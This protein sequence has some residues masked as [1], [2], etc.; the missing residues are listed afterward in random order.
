MSQADVFVSVVAV[1]RNHAR[2][3][4]EFVEELTQ[5][6][7]AH[8]AN[9]EILLVDNA[10]TDETGS[11]ARAL[12]RE[13][14]SLRYMPLTR[15][16]HDETAVLSG[17]N[18]SIGDYVVTLDPEFDPPGEIVSMVRQC[19][20][21]S[22]VVFGVTDKSSGESFAYKVARRLF[23]AMAGWFVNL[24]HMT[25][26]TGY[27]VLSRTAVNAVV[28]VRLRRPFIA[29]IASEF[30]LSTS[31]YA[32]TSISRFGA[33]RTRRI[34]KASRIAGSLIVHHSFGPLRLAS[35]MGLIGSLL[36]FLYSLYVIGVY[37]SKDD[38]MPG[39]TTLSLSITGLFTLMFLILALMGEYLGRLLEESTVRPLYHMQ[40]EES[41]SVMLSNPE[42]HN[43]L[44]PSEQADASMVGSK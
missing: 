25:G 10:S 28:R 24:D 22:D 15:P 5:L 18:A 21:Q 6:L 2:I 17:L 16:M 34:S 44:R 30:G 27:R 37:L 40:D 36:C 1:I 23:R 20:T 8:F 31:T 29:M 19:A 35:T 11:I 43:V 38:V 4:P 14:P 32:Y 26:R 33:R 39:W 7:S 3:L 12:L 42:R 9:H 41:S 13:T